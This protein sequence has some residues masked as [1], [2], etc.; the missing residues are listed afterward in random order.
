MLRWSVAN[1]TDV[2]I[3]TGI[4]T[5][6]GSGS[7]NVFPTST[8]TY[9]LSAEGPGGN[10]SASAMVE[11]T[12]AAPAVA[13]E[14]PSLPPDF[15]RRWKEIQDAF[16]AY[17]KSNLDES[18]RAT[19][20]KNADTLK[21]ILEDFGGVSIVLEGHCDDRGSAE[22]NLAL[23]D[24]RSASSKDFLTQLGVPADRLKTL[25]YGKERP[26]CA[27]EDENCWQRNRRVHLLPS[28]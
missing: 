25:S 5:V 19:M 10:D 28:K 15:N 6:A 16:F 11:V 1:A 3:N 7:R 21:G 26:Q 24:R 27:D 23:G 14:N 20:V 13:R 2:S 22:Y 8:T 12:V 4:G 17:D 18:A 9:T